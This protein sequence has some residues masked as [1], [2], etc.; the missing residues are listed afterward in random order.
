MN[1]EKARLNKILENQEIKMMITAFGT[2]IG[3]DF[4]MDKL[5]YDKI[6]CM[7]DA[8]VDVAHIR[9]L[10]LTFFF[11]FMRPLLE[12]GHVYAAKPP[13]YKV[14]KN[15]EDFYFY[16]DQ[17]LEEWYQTNGRKGCAQQRYKGLG[18]MNAT[19]LL[20]TT[21]NPESRILIQLTI[22]DAIEAEKMFND[23]MGEDVEL[24]RKFI[25]ENATL[26]SPDDIDA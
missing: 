18:E 20:D 25:Q 12:E 15:K 22:E 11:R 7:S 9:I 3:Q 26:V 6:I 21:M 16:S 23:L 10:L 24:R 5:R 14:T 13:L 4:N 8:D 1:V 19:Q 17:E 2:G